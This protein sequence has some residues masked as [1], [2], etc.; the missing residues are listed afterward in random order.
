M[1]GLAADT[2]IFEFLQFPEV[3]ELH[4]IEWQL[5]LSEKEHLTD[6]CKRLA[7]KIIHPNPIL[8]GV[9]FGGIIVQELKSMVNA[10]QVFIISSIKS[11]KEM[12]NRLKLLQKTKTYK[13]F[14]TGAVVNLEDFTKY[15]FGDMAKRKM[16]QYKKYLSVR[17]KL[18][19]N[20]AIHNVLHWDRLEAD[21]E[22]IHLHGNNDHIFP[23]KNIKNFILIEEGTHAMVMMKA[24]KV[25]KIIQDHLSC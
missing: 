24:K 13:L 18:Y 3:Y 22:V 4:F 23:S 14:P 7:E 9:S 25:S 17:D 19:L 20:W 15:A 21:P 16:K 11:R 5:P 2:S 6:Y 1:P 10:S 12:P 8:V